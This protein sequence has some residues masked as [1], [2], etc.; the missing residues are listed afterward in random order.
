VWIIANRLAQA[1]SNWQP[2]KNE[3]LVKTEFSGKLKLV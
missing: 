3:G 1:E 2:Y